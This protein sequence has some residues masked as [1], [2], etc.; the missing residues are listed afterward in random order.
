[1]ALLVAAT[2]SRRARRR[3]RLAGNRRSSSTMT[4][5]HSLS[6][7]A[8]SPPQASAQIEDL[9]RILGR[10]VRAHQLYQGKN[11][12]LERFSAD[13]EQAF[14]RIWQ[15]ESEIVLRIEEGRILW[16]GQPVY[17]EPGGQENLAFVFYKDGVRQLTFHPG[18]ETE[19]LRDFV[20]VLARVHRVQ[21]DEDDLITLLWESN[22]TH[23][24]HRYV[25]SLAEGVELPAASGGEPGSVSPEEVRSEASGVTSTVSR[26]DFQEA[27]Y[28]L[29][30]GEMRRLAEEIDREA[31]RDLWGDVFTAL[32]DQVE[33]GRDE[34][35]L[36]A[37]RVIRDL[38]PGLLGSGSL[39]RAAWLLEEMAAIAVKTPP[40]PLP[41]LRE[42]QDVFITISTPGAVNQLV[43]TLEDAPEAMRGNALARLIRFFPPE[44][45][46][47][48]IRATSSTGRA[49]V[50]E[51]LGGG[52]RALAPGRE[53][54]L[55]GLLDD[56]DPRMVEGAARWIAELRLETA[57]P[58]LAELLSRDDVDVRLAAVEA[59]QVLHTSVGAGALVRALD[60]PDRGV[61]IAAAR[62]LGA[63]RY[64]PARAQVEAVIGSR[65]IRET[66][67]TERIAFFE[68]F[69]SLAGPDGVKL[70]EKI[71]V[72]KSML[73][74]RET[75][76]MRASA[77]LGLGR[78]DDQRARA[79]L[80]AVSGD[81][82]P[83]VRSAVLRAMRAGNA[84]A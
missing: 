27:L 19:E 45:L 72:G 1:M 41:V 43:L 22:F 67:I 64:A 83:V 24:D 20:A 34:L 7:P 62:A 5:T 77:A 40:P 18:F 59:M 50:R 79:V 8:A 31:R 75:P 26:E 80:A 61:R 58:R 52:I 30:E 17:A 76:E 14:T 15:S 56:E 82:E 65:R 55:I 28:F 73:G 35:R 38:L 71:L 66:D 84:P 2:P 68:A 49:D 16:E 78:I 42:M 25:D 57:A 37:V 33:I 21:R 12:V 39:D 81:A 48:L 69:G 47:V 6:Q 9:L 54:I 53:G 70:L 63:L 46:P 29:D 23:L 10:T 60:D 32:L 44:A 11:P 36:R 3:F 4:R 74:R 51:A 13:M